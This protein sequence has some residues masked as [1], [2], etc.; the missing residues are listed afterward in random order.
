M[1]LPKAT[2]PF[3]PELMLQRVVR[4]LATVVSADRGGRRAG[5]GTAAACRRSDRRPR[6]ARRPR[7]A[8]RVAGRAGRNRA[9]RRR[10]LCDE[11]RRA[12][13]GAGVRAGDDRTAGG[14]DIAVP[15]EGEFPHPLA[16][17]YR[18][19]VLPHIR[20]LLA[21]DRLRPAFLFERVATCRVPVGRAAGR[22]SAA[23]H[24]AKSQPAG[25]LSGGA[26]GGGVGG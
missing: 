2:L 18:T 21:A 23:D 11:L 4:L 17:V 8:G 15:V 5:A 22:R 1:G 19:S 7:A 14:R 6:R 20:E 24:A 3:G 25:R 9:A 13:A 26:G 10:R 16:A 12:A